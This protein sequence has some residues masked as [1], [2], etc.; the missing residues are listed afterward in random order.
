MIFNLLTRCYFFL[1]NIWEK[2]CQ[3]LSIQM[4]AHSP[5]YKF[6]TVSSKTIY[7]MK[8]VV[9][10]NGDTIIIFW[11]NFYYQTQTQNQQLRGLGLRDHYVKKLIKLV[12]Q[13]NV[14]P[15]MYAKGLH[16]SCSNLTQPPLVYMKASGSP[17]YYLTLYFLM[18][19]A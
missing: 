4:Y 19:I 11:G 10:I 18:I 15:A 14:T 6:K 9:C 17:I 12:I 5:L 1:G 3:K 7:A 16:K 8:I 2:Q 13:T